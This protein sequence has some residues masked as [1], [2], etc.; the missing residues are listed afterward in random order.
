MIDHRKFFENLKLGIV[1][2]KK[3]NIFKEKTH[4]I[5]EE[6]HVLIVCF[7]II[8]IQSQTNFKSTIRKAAPL[9]LH[10]EEGIS[11]TDEN[12]GGTEPGCR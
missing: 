11:D 10:N 9:R 2:T 4:L 8:Q 5:C 7:E 1:H 3:K 6:V 12:S